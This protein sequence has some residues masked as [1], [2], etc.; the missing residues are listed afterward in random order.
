MKIQSTILGA[1]VLMSSACFAQKDS[2]FSWPAKTPKY[3]IHLE[4]ADGNKISG[5]LVSKTDSSVVIYPGNASSY[6]KKKLYSSAVFMDDQIEKIQIRRRNA[7]ARG[8]LIGL[9]VGMVPVIA[10]VFSGK[11]AESFAYAS[12]ISVPLGTI[13]GT[14][15]GAT[16]SRKFHIGK[17]KDKYKKFSASVK[18]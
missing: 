7:V 18:L 16:S 10:A 3:K 14:V 5:L 1:F 6:N 12:I 9:G 17:E 4:A 11:N 8:A 13:V 2:S 15:I